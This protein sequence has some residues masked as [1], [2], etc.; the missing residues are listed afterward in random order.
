M[1]ARVRPLFSASVQAAGMARDIEEKD[2]GLQINLK[3]PFGAALEY[4][5]QEEYSD[6][7][8]TKRLRYWQDS[9]LRWNGSSWAI[10]PL[11]DIREKLWRLGWGT[12]NFKRRH[13]D[14]CVDALRSVCNLSDTVAPPCWID[15]VSSDPSPENL[16]AMRNGLLNVSTRTLL[17][18][19]PRFFVLTA[20]PFRWLPDAPPPVHWLAFLRDLFG[21][22][23]ESID[24]L[25]EWFGYALTH[26]TEM[27]K[28]LMLVGPRR[29]GK[30]TILKVLAALVGE[31]NRVSPGLSS[32]GRPFG[33]SCLIG[34]RLAFIA[35]GR[36]SGR[37]DMAVIVE[38]LLRISGGDAVTVD[39][40]YQADYT[41]TLPV[42]FTWATNELPAFTDAAGALP[43]R[44]LILKLTRSFFGHEDQALLPR[45]MGELQGILLWALEGLDRLNERGCF[46]P[47]V[48]SEQLIGELD[49]LASPVAE[50]LKDCCWV[51][52]PAAE[53]ECGVLFDEW[54]AWC[55]KN[56][57]E[58]VGTTAILGRDLRAAL[59]GLQVVHRREK[60]RRI[61]M[62]QGVR[63]R[64]LQDPAEAGEVID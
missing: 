39:R 42:L 23:Q 25:A 36:L 35:D 64:I 1:A 15:R 26:S 5:A 12:E 57:R 29:S 49:A 20:L 8:K 21:D 13:V 38:N 55:E 62:Y 43:G 58:R 50:F 56:G 11:Q 33:L 59:P 7:S 53:V 30:G 63:L 48:S 10:V 40:K 52:D 2:A 16:I 45:L 47:P 54:K 46:A 22:D 61:R 37:S 3:D 31:A 41:A 34:K 60:G 6:I 28:M 19:N 14:D 17:K 44:F 4:V 24:L 18:P 32:L 9:F 51:R 27:H